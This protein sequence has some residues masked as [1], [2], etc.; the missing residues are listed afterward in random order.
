[1]QQSAHS[2]YNAGSL[3]FISKGRVMNL[4]TLN[5]SVTPC[6]V[7]DYPFSDKHHIWPQSKGGKAL[8]TILLCPN[9]HRFANLVQVMLMREMQRGQIEA[10]AHK[11]FDIAFNT[12]VL[13]LLITEHERLSDFGWDA[14]AE[15]RAQEAR[16]DPESTLSSAQAFIRDAKARLALMSPNEPVPMAE[17]LEAFGHMEAVIAALEF[18]DNREVSL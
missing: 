13:A 16:A 17:R 5:I 8:P 10:F 3:I 2:Q 9:H 18:L 1:M 15:Q 6:V 7:C 14:Y 4:N 12:R 11:Y